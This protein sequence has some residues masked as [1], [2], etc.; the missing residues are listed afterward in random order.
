MKNNK[1]IT[2]IALV[3]T[4]V[5]MLI[6]VVVVVTDVRDGGLFDYAAN[7]VKSTKAVSEDI[8]I[9]QAAAIAMGMDSRGRITEIELKNQMD[10]YNDVESVTAIGDYFVIEF[11]NGKQF[12]LNQQ[13]DIIEK[14]GLLAYEVTSQNF[15]NY[16]FNYSDIDVLDGG[17]TQL[18]DWQIF[19]AGKVS[20]EEEDHIYLITSNIIDSSIKPATGSYPNGSEDV[21][22]ETRYLNSE[23][24][25]YLEFNNKTSTN[26]NMKTVA[27]LCDTSKWNTFKTDKADFAIG[28]PTLELFIKA[29]NKKNNTTMKYGYMTEDGEGNTMV[30]QGSDGTNT[31]TDSGY[32][33]SWNGTSGWG[34][35]FIYKFDTR[36]PYYNS[37]CYWFASPGCKMNTL[38]S[39]YRTQGISMDSRDATVYYR[40]VVRLKA[41]TQLERVEGG[42]R[43]VE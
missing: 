37:N 2:I 25:K 16:V 6:L 21:A 39:F 30:A 26:T 14:E 3:I 23:F 34:N 4:I 13:A 27:Y 18:A 11:K 33:V 10:K 9:Q 22:E 42:Y 28:A 1:G 31:I 7:S 35:G 40:P 32:K 17:E 5:L 36:A 38:L 19:Y 24:Y 41:D 8:E 20:D 29:Y 12:I 43:I 15:G